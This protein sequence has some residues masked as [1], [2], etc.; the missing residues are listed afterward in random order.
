MYHLFLKKELIAWYAIYTYSI[1]TQIEHVLE[2]KA[3]IY[4]HIS[5]VFGVWCLG[6]VIYFQRSYGYKIHED[7]EKRILGFYKLRIEIVLFYMSKCS[8]AA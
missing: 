3:R 5:Y 2:K 1:K 8:I 7:L 6:K 4:F